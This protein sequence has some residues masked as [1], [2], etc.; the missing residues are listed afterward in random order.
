MRVRFKGGLR[1]AISSSC[2]A[3]SIGLAA[4]AASFQGC[5][6]LSEIRKN[7][8]ELPSETEARVTQDRSSR[9]QSYS[10][11]QEYRESVALRLQKE[12]DE[13]LARQAL[14]KEEARTKAYTDVGL[15]T[16][17][18]HA[19]AGT[20]SPEEALEFKKLRLSDDEEATLTVM[21][22]QV[23]DWN[24]AG[25]RVPESIAW[26]KAQ[27]NMADA[28]KWR[29]AGFG[30]K[31]A[32]NIEAFGVSDPVQGKK[33]VARC[34]KGVEA[35]DVL[36][37]TNPYDVTGR[38]FGFVGTTRQILSRTTGLYLLGGAQP[39]LVNF[40]E[41]SAPP[42]LFNGIVK[43]LGSYKYTTVSGSQKIVSSVDAVYS[44]ESL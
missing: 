29:K 1:S 13:D 14:A 33:I 16:G 36:Y 35:L 9:Q 37:Q 44:R 24:A 42:H 41:R 2:L 15:S 4:M 32:K 30:P 11:P 10:P 12:A 22:R 18:A 27:F 25:F 40:G 8:I 5:A 19:W 39:V 6:R 20:F 21:G 3:R 43:G 38:C 23:Y 28:D 26:N 17:L 31:K 7:L 34:P